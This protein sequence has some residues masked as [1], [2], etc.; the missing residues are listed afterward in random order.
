MISGELKRRSDDGG[1]GGFGNFGFGYRRHRG[2][3]PALSAKQRIA[4]HGSCRKYTLKS[5]NVPAATRLQQ[6]RI[7]LQRL[8][9]L[10]TPR[11]EDRYVLV[12]AAAFQLEAVD[13]YQVELR[14]H[15]IVGKPERQT[16]TVRATIRA[17]NFFP[18][19]RVPESWPRST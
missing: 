8:R 3:D 1:F 11:V 10:M 4:G 12:N 17:L 15:V 6:L 19:W 7:N 16:P 5:L 13:H 2:G 9:D 14:H 18:Y